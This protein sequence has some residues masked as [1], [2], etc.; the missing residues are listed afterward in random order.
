LNFQGLNASLAPA[1]SSLY[2]WRQGRK[3]ANEPGP[4]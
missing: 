1:I 2:D 3:K 4:S